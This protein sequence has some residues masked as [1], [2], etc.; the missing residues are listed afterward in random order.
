VGESKK[1]IDRIG[2]AAS[3]E[4]GFEELLQSLVKAK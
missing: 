2:A 1:A 4:K 3:R